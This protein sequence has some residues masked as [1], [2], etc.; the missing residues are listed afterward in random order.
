MEKYKLSETC[1]VLLW[2]GN[3]DVVGKIKKRIGIIQCWQEHDKIDHLMK[4]FADSVGRAHFLWV[5]NMLT[6]YHYLKYAYPLV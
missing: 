4:C 6:V 5:K 3:R 1:F 2:K